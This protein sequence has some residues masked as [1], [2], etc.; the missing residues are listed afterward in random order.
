MTHLWPAVTLVYSNFDIFWQKSYSGSK[1]WNSY[2]F[3]HLI[4]IIFLKNLENH[5]FL[6]KC[7][8][9]ISALQEFN[10]LLFDFFSI[11]DL[12]F[13]LMMLHVLLNFVICWV[14]L[15]K[16]EITDFFFPL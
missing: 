9:C 15:W 11:V 8:Y 1:Q 16:E 6:L 10:L 14:Y 5:I 4:W 3:F 2:L 7:M 13:I 12:Q